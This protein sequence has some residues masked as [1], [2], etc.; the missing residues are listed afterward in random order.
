MGS[1]FYDGTLSSASPVGTIYPPLAANSFLRS[2]PGIY[3]IADIFKSKPGTNA[4]ASIVSDRFTAFFRP[5]AVGRGWG[6]SQRNMSLVFPE[7]LHWYGQGKSD[8]SDQGLM[9]AFKLSGESG[10]ISSHLEQKCR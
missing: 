8:Y 4:I 3:S 9:D 1:S 6:S 5:S 2:N 10:S 7:G